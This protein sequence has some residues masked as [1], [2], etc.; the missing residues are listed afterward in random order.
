MQRDA[1]EYT[2]KQYNVQL[3]AVVCDTPAR[4]FAKAIGHTGYH[5]CDKCIQERQYVPNHMTF[6][7][8]SAALH[9]DESFAAKSDVFHHLGVSPFSCLCVGMI[10]N[11]P[12]DYVHSVCLGVMQKLLY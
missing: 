4:A 2:D 10:S 1:F 12:I 3:S 7:E 6:P 11:F 5:G 9:T 8:I